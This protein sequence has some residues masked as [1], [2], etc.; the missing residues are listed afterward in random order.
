MVGSS[1]VDQ[2]VRRLKASGMVNRIL[3]SICVAE[4]INK[5][6]V[7]A[8]LQA[9]IIESKSMLILRKLRRS[10]SSDRSRRLLFVI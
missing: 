6:G 1:E 10:P 3:Q 4:G 2:L 5:N 9:R 7:K 8:D